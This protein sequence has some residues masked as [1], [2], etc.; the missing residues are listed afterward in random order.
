MKALI[1]HG[2]PYNI[3][4]FNTLEYFK[5]ECL[6]P[7]NGGI[8]GHY[9]Y[10]VTKTSDMSIIED[11]V[12]PEALRHACKSD[13]IRGKEGTKG[14]VYIYLIGINKF[15]DSE[16]KEPL[17]FY[18]EYFLEYFSEKY[19]TQMYDKLETNKQIINHITNQL[20][21]R[22]DYNIVADILSYT[23]YRGMKEPNM[24]GFSTL[25][26]WDNTFITENKLIQKLEAFKIGTG[27]QISNYDIHEV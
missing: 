14:F 25:Y 24:L 21:K 15:M 4:N 3:T 6:S 20:V 1:F 2:S 27:S 19:L 8:L 13:N 10:Y 23:G 9:F 26:C 16:A 5:E 7:Y 12:I 22:F 17:D 11:F 18:I